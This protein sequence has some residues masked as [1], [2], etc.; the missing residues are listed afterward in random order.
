MKHMDAE[1]KEGNRWNKFNLGLAHK[2]WSTNYY[3][4]NIYLC[5]YYLNVIWSI[6]IF[7]EVLK[8]GLIIEVPSEAKEGVQGAALPNFFKGLQTQNTSS[9]KK[10]IWS[11]KTKNPKI[12]YFINPEKFFSMILLLLHGLQQVVV[13]C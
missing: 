9:E 3:L 4:T 2:N 13:K 10:C 1:K 11:F 12:S 7:I 5:F 8:L 6:C